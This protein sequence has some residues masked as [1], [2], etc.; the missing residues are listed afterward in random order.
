MVCAKSKNTPG[1]LEI[2]NSRVGRDYE[3]GDKFEAGI[4]LKGTEVKSIRSGHCQIRDGFVRI[5]GNNAFLHNVHVEEYLFGN[6]N[7]HQIN[8]P[9]QLLL[10]RREIDKL[11]GAQDME[12]KSIIPLK[13][14]AKSGL[15][16]IQIAICKGKRNYD[17]R[18]DLK[19]K[20]Q[21][22]EIERSLKKRA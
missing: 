17:K 2:R 18:Q 22:R 19:K 11:R 6:T 8:R 7:N 1:K 20:E 13:L 15:I 9:R 12:G 16:K 4:A 14:Y 21:M 5:K 3:I 10:H